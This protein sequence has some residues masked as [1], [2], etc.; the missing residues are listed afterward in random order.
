MNNIWQVTNTKDLIDIMNTCRDKF[1]IIGLTLKSTPHNQKKIIKQFFREK[2][3][4]YPN[5]TFI[6]YQV[7]IDDLGK[8]ISLLKKS[9]DEYP[10][11]YHIYNIDKILVN[12]SNVNE[13]TILESFN[14]VKQYYDND[15]YKKEVIPKWD[16]IPLAKSARSLEETDPKLKEKIILLKNKSEEYSINLL[17]DIQNRKKIESK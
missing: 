13:I 4:E 10:Y 6:Y 8:H 17:K 5:I 2:H 16:N 3:I 9:P 12:V 14:A 11:L 15:K 1:S 7:N